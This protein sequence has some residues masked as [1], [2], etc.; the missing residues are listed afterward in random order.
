VFCGSDTVT[1][2]FKQ[3]QFNAIPNSPVPRAEH[4]NTSFTN[5]SANY[6]HTKQLVGEKSSSAVCGV[7]KTDLTLE[8]FLS[9]GN[10]NMKANY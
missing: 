6:R 7:I 2:A 1:A 5:P 3:S 9:A 8:V 10:G 4:A